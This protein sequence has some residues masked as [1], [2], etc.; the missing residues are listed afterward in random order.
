MD[1]IN[2]SID[3]QTP[4]QAALQG[5]QL[6][7]AIRKDQTEQQQQELA[8]QQQRL[9][10]QVVHSLVTNPNA[11]A[12]DYANATLLVPSLKDQ[13][14]QSWDTKN[15]QQQQNDLSHVS[16]IYA[17]LQ[18]QQP[19]VAA[20]LLEQRAQALRNSGNEDE[21]KSNDVL[22]NVVREHPEFARTLVGLKLAS[23]PG[24][25]KVLTSAGSLETQ[26]ATVRKANAEATS[27]EVTA[28]NATTAASLDNETKAQAIK[29]AEAQRKVADLN[30]Q[31]A[32]A[33]SETQ[34][35]QLIM[36]RDKWQAELNKTKQ[37]QSNASQDTMDSLTQGLQTIKSIR[38]HPGLASNGV[39]LGGVGS[40]S[41]K[42]SGLIPGTDRKDLEGLVDT[43]KSQQ[44]LSGIKQMTGLGQLSNAEGEKIGS[45]VASLN[46]DQ[47]PKAF[48]N[49]LSVIETNLN[50]A[51][52]KLVARGQAPTDGTTTP[53]IM[54]HPQF[55]AVRD[56]DLNRLMKKYPGQTREQILQ[57]LRDTGGK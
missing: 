43:L 42:I 50:K 51:Q 55:G 38:E 6:G 14:R 1:P 8:L 35:G 26:P 12:Q 57:F 33:N 22:A 39:G 28:G 2:Y 18:G 15:A 36:E 37:A 25:D 17:A 41:G 56:A 54:Q 21:A 24:G 29:T 19:E 49:A 13:F 5:Y 53:V 52:A 7:S 30:V 34:R 20:S 40:I 44:F 11:T 27:A 46:L 4:F 23:I 47:S 31:I 45:A 10:A 3:V 16:Q 32:Q 48:N 9:Q